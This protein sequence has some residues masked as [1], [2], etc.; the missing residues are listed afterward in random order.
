MPTA[1]ASGCGCKPCA[2]PTTTFP[3]RSRTTSKRSTWPSA[4]GIEPSSR[5]VAGCSWACS[6]RPTIS[7]RRSPGSPPSW[8]PGPS[9]A[10]AT[11]APRWPNSWHCSP[12]RLSRWCF[13]TP[14]RTPRE[15]GR[16]SGH[17]GD[18]GGNG[19]GRVHRRIPGRSRARPA[20]RR[21]TRPPAHHPS[22]QRPHPALTSTHLGKRPFGGS[23]PDARTE[24]LHWWHGLSWGVSH[25]WYAVF[26]S[27]GSLFVTS[28]CGLGVFAG[29][30]PCAA[31]F[32]PTRHR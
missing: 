16:F 17:V 28:R 12:T 32:R 9:Q 1:R 31:R 25:G 30:L 6:L 22:P 5:P 8:T 13:Q 24:P 20:Q 26:L 10:T 4:S 21:R 14:G 15:P 19:S 29:A 23:Q 27:D 7:T 18:A 2:Q 3:L 11:R